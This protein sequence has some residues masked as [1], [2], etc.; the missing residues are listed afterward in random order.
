MSD[1]EHKRRPGPS[2]FGEDVKNEVR[3]WLN[4][5]LAGAA[6]GA[7]VGAALGLYLFAATGALYGAAVGTVVGAAAAAYF[8]FDAST[9][10]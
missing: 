7:V 4:W 3:S 10:F 8:A 2:S 1:D 5:A 9:G 6:L